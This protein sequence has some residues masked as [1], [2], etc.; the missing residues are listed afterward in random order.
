MLPRP[1]RLLSGLRFVRGAA[2]LT[3]QIGFWLALV[4]GCGIDNRTLKLRAAD[5]GVD[6]SGGG[7]VA[8]NTAKAPDGGVI[9][10]FLG[11]D[12]FFEYATPDNAVLNYAAGNG[13]LNLSGNQAGG[14][15]REYEGVTLLFLNCIDASAFSGVAFAIEG[16]VSGC[17]MQ[18]A[19]DFSADD[20]SP[21]LGS[22]TGP[23]CY[24]PQ[25]SVFPTSTATTLEFPW[26]SLSY[27]PGDPIPNPQ[28]PTTIVGIQWQFTIP[29]VSDGGSD[30]CLADVTITDLRFYHSDP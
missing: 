4:S 13:A 14:P 25:S 9:A 3:A 11:D 19:T 24:S 5:G 12:R 7:C 18:Y 20:S 21:Q 16:S 10:T 28:D 27:A 23:S 2:V 8:S 6:G 26:A 1:S 15:N 29:P 30:V 17:T 22:C